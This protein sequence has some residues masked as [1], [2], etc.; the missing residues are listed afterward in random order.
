MKPCAYIRR[1]KV[2]PR[3]QNFSGI[4]GPRYRETAETETCGILE[5]VLSE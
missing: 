4:Y 5:V 1:V 3:I 2:E